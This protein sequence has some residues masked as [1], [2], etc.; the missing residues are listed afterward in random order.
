MRAGLVAKPEQW[1]DAIKR[2]GFE[3]QPTTG[4]FQDK[5]GWLTGVRVPHRTMD[6]GPVL[7]LAGAALR[8]E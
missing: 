8:E 1:V 5:A 4:N 3:V 6:I 7:R 2:S